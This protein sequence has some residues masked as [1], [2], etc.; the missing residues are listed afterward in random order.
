MADPGETSSLGKQ[1][2][3]LQAERSAAMS[4]MAAAAA[5]VESAAGEDLRIL[6]IYLIGI[7]LCYSYIIII[8]I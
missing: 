3:S 5:S 2:Q 6:A 4:K 7:I 1:V 8:I